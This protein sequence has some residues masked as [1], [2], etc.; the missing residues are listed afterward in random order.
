MGLF[1][2]DKQWQI[3]DKMDSLNRL[4]VCKFVTTID[5]ETLFLGPCVDPVADDLKMSV[6]DSG[7]EMNN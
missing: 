5:D 4:E 1:Y 3:E 7:S 6:K 2:L